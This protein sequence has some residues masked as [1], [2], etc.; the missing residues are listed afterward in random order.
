MKLLFLIDKNL[1]DDLDGPFFNFHP[2]H[3]GPFDRKVYDVLRNL[4]LKGM[5]NFLSEHTWEDYQLT[6]IGL[7]TGVGIF[8]EMNE[9][10]REYIQAISEFV[11][12][13]SFSELV[14]SIYKKYPEMRENSVF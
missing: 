13:L 5:V 9:K 3:Y 8:E 6:E 10:S 11:R 12:S 14:S 7:S 1:A 4:R 2:Y